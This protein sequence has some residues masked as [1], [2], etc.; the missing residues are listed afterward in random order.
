MVLQVEVMVVIVVVV[1]FGRV[2]TVG[3]ATV[4]DNI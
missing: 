2:S 1:D 3:E 4:R